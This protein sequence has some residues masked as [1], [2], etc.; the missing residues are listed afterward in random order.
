MTSRFAYC[1]TSA[2]ILISA[3]FEADA[4]YNAQMQNDCQQPQSI[5]VKRYSDF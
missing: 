2:M 5:Y 1:S 3:Q 4:Q